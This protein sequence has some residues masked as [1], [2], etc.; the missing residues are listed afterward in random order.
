MAECLFNDQKQNVVKPADDQQRS[1]MRHKT[2]SVM[3]VA[4][5]SGADPEGV[6]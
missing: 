2:C 3:S 1:T 4:V 5:D 6:V